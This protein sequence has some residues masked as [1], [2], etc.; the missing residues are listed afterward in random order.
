MFLLKHVA[1]KT[2]RHRP[3]ANLDCCWGIELS[4][5]RRGRNR[6]CAV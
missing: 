4:G 6:I 3:S 2:G 1:T 5:R